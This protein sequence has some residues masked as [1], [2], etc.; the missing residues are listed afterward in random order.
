MEP[1]E[2]MTPYDLQVRTGRGAGE[3]TRHEDVP[4]PVE[5]DVVKVDTHPR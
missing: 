3:G 2:R 5:A 4:A 1:E